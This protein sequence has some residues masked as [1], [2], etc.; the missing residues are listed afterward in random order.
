M[1]CCPRRSA[2]AWTPGAGR[3]RGALARLGRRGARR[4][5]P[6]RATPAA[7]SG[8]AEGLAL[9]AAAFNGMPD[10]VFHLAG[11]AMTIVTG[12]AAIEP[13]PPGPSR[14]VILDAALQAV[15][16]LQQL[17]SFRPRLHHRD[18]PCRAATRHRYP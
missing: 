8:A 4:G 6:E 3:N 9:H 17:L 11:R 16:G 10:P 5:P 15:T 18:Q 7:D 12:L 14:D 2:S 1:R 13:D